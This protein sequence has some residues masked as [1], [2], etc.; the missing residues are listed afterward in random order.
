MLFVCT[1]INPNQKDFSGISFN[2]VRIPSILD[3]INCTFGGFIPLQ[4]HYKP[5]RA[6]QRLCKAILAA[7]FYRTH[8]YLCNLL[9]RDKNFL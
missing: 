8:K 3:L 5:F 6:I 9:V 1:I 7:H 4:F 2:P